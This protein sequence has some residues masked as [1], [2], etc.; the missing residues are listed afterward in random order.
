MDAAAHLVT[1]SGASVSNFT[2]LP[3]PVLRRY[4]KR[5]NQARQSDL[6]APPQKSNGLII[7]NASK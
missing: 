5:L 2:F 4:E 1:T 3:S 6:D 7:M